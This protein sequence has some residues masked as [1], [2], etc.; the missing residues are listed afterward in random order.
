MA[1]SFV[2]SGPGSFNIS[3]RTGETGRTEVYLEKDVDPRLLT[4]QEGKGLK[5][6]TV[7]ESSTQLRGE[8]LK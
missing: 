8:V 2:E 7:I 5:S 6:F 1:P 4:P 3:H